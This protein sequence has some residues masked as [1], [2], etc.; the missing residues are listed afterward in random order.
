MANKYIYSNIIGSFIIDNNFKIVDTLKFKNINDFLDK[1]KF[2][3]KLIK[4]F[5][6]VEKINPKKVLYLFKDKKY[7]SEL[8]NKNLEL[9]K[10]RIKESVGFDNLIIQSISNIE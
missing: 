2:E 4:K 9:T 1:E 5:K 7:F 10:I 8:Y 3:Q 6:K